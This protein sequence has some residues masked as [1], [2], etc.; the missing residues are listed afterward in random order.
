MILA[1]FAEPENECCEVESGPVAGREFVE[2]GRDGPELLSRLKQRST[3]LR[4]L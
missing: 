1:G 2:A 3:T 4:T